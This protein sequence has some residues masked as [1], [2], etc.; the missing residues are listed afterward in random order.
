MSLSRARG[1]MSMAAAAPKSSSISA[2]AA[3]ASPLRRSPLLPCR[4]S[5][6]RRA[7]PALRF[8]EKDELEREQRGRE[9]EAEAK[10]E[11]AAEEVRRSLKEIKEAAEASAAEAK[12]KKDQA[13]LPPQSPREAALVK[14]IPFYVPAFTRYKEKAVGRVAMAAMAVTTVL[15]VVRPDHPGP[16]RQIAQNFGWPLATVELAL[17]VFVF[18]GL[19]ALF[20][21]SPTYSDANARDFLRRQP[22]PPSAMA[23]PFREPARF[24]GVAPWL[25]G[26][27]KRVE[28]LHGRLAM[29]AFLN[30]CIQEIRTGG[31]GF[32]GQAAFL[33]GKVGVDVGSTGV[34]LMPALPPDEWYARAAGWLLAWSVFW[35]AMAYA[36]GETGQT[37][38]GDDVY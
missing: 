36:R 37:K 10:R 25:P 28:L 29:L 33:L 13:P 31:L 32:L 8:K 17:A 12:H 22:G 24:F 11:R 7:P 30:I 19:L 34:D 35:T 9:R 21:S 5:S 26:F 2:A 20:P 38:G 23:N 14:S 6:G 18:H 27:T 16:L 4:R 3:A 1:L 15:E